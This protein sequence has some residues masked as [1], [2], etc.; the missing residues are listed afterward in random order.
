MLHQHFIHVGCLETS[1]KCMGTIYNCTQQVA[2]STSVSCNSG[3]VQ[4][5]SY[6]KV[7]PCKCWILRVLPLG[8]PTGSKLVGMLASKSGQGRAISFI[9]R[10]VLLTLKPQFSLKECFPIYYLLYNCTLFTTY[11]RKFPVY[12]S[13]VEGKVLIPCVQMNVNQ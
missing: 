1:T 2:E 13:K 10:G 12:C 4:P 8:P 3:L 5:K 7:A 6:A 11:S 9:T